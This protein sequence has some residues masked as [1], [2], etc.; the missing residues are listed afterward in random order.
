MEV[1]TWYLAAL[2]QVM[3]CNWRVIANLHLSNHAKV[4]HAI[5]LHGV[6]PAHSQQKMLLQ[7]HSRTRE[8]NTMRCSC[9]LPASQP[10]LHPLIPASIS[11]LHTCPKT[12]VYHSTRK[13]KHYSDI[14]KQNESAALLAELILHAGLRSISGAQPSHQ[15]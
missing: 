12:R 15:N 9:N 3:G 13:A 5:G 7:Y 14:D 4:S 2:R 10:A 6:L 1:N 11:L 8:A